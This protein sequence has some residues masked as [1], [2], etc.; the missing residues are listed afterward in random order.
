MLWASRMWRR[1]GLSWW[2]LLG[3]GQPGIQRTG[4]VLVDAL[5][6]NKVNGASFYGRG[7]GL[8][9]GLCCTAFKTIINLPTSQSYSVTYGRM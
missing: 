1:Y 9:D 3:S 8:M 5:I 7:V 6:P 2:L 4:P